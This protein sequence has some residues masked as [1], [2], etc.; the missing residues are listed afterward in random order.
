MLLIRVARG[1]IEERK[2]K[3]FTLKLAEKVIS[4]LRKGG[5]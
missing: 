2:K 3:V 4:S 1:V 5:A